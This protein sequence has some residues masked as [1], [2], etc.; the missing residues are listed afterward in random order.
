MNL[1]EQPSL[2]NEDKKSENVQED[3]NPKNIE[4]ES[5]KYFQ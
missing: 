4:S 1:I 2:E 5:S 3:K